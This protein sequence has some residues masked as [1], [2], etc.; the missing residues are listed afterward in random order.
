MA[1]EEL[2]AIP[3]LATPAPQVSKRT[4][5]VA[6]LLVDVYGLDEVA[7]TASRVSCLWLHHGRLRSK[8]NMADIAA[9]C[10]GAWNCHGAAA[11]KRG[12]IALASDARNH[13]TRLVHE[14]ANESWKQGNATHAQD[15]FGAV[16]GAVADQIV[17]LD[18]IGG[19]LFHES[20]HR[21][22]DH[23]VALGVSMGG[24]SVWQLMFADPRIRAGVVVIGCPD[25][26]AMLSHRAKRSKITDGSG[27]SF[28]GSKEFPQSLVDACL[29]FDPKGIFFGTSDVPDDATSSSPTD[30]AKQ[31]QIL[32]DRLHEKKFLLCSGADDRLV[33]YSCGEP[34]LRWFKEATGSQF[35]VE[36]ISVTDKVYP[37]IGHEFSAEMVDDAVSFIIDEVV[38]ASGEDAAADAHAGREEARSSKI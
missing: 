4:I 12:L 14:K 30:Q 13:G 16:S 38:T 26:M 5:H 11:Q 23:H 9:R 36:R 29:K 8:D 21:E 3:A 2:N 6:G 28:L 31:K 27:A 24:H 25:F 22:I 20:D 15:M 19:Y 34:F 33:P 17:L 7:P 10:V 1:A 37:S 18:A 32:H 35:K